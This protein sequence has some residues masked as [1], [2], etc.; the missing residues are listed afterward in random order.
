MSI[1]TAVTSQC[2]IMM[3]SHSKHYSFRNVQSDTL[4]YVKGTA[5]YWLNFV[6]LTS[7][8]VSG[9]AWPAVSPVA[10]DSPRD[11][12]WTVSSNNRVLLWFLM[13]YVYIYLCFT[14]WYADCHRNA[15][16]MCPCASY[17]IGKLV[18]GACAGNAGNVFPTTDFKWDSQL[19][20]PASITARAWRTCRDVCR[21]R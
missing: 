17:H 7:R 6:F 19:A 1:T 3:T 4:S 16:M 18:G 9:R 10:A 15:S 5:E 20:I 11:V 14:S 13:R 12:W 2:H 21:G 8:G